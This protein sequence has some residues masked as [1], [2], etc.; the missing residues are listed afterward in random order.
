MSDEAIH[1]LLDAFP[2]QFLKKVDELELSTRPA[3]CLKR[4]DIVYIGD[5]VQ[6]SEAE[7]LRIQN[8]GSESLNEIKG[9]LAE[10]GLRL[11]MRILFHHVVVATLAPQ[12]GSATDG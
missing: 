1:A 4:A 11:G 5:L 12:P 7:M 2:Q 8:L 3:N 10:I 6:R 9:V